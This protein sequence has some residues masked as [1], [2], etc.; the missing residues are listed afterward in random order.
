[1]SEPAYSRAKKLYVDREG[2]GRNVYATIPAAVAEANFGDVVYISP[3]KYERAT[4]KSGVQLSGQGLVV[5]SSL[6]ASSE[7]PIH[8]EPARLNDLIFTVAQ[9]PAQ[10]TVPIVAQNCRWIFTA[11]SIMGGI[12]GLTTSSR[13][14]FHGCQFKLNWGLPHSGVTLFRLDSGHLTLRN[15][16]IDLTDGPKSTV[17]VVQ[18]ASTGQ[19]KIGSHITMI[20]N[21]V[22]LREAG[23]SNF[24]V[25]SLGKDVIEEI[26]GNSVVAQNLTPT[27][28][29]TFDWGLGSDARYNKA[30]LLP[31]EAWQPA[32]SSLSAATD[33]SITQG[34]PAVVLPIRSM[35]ESGHITAADHTILMAANKPIT[36]TLPKAAG[37]MMPGQL[38]GGQVLKIKNIGRHGSNTHSI[39]CQPGNLYVGPS[40]IVPGQKLTIQNYGATWHVI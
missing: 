38:V 31:M 27:Q 30:T 13:N 33:N 19:T 35:S 17:T 34:S 6:E 26:Q 8:V 18:S 37:L 15:C 25:V 4:V 9:G 32:M 10:M 21:Q 3:G 40:Q 20:G 23:G 16:L 39:E 22:H 12:T 1:M 29:S 2:K 5:I 14:E 24:R 28:K 36:A 7:T 11:S